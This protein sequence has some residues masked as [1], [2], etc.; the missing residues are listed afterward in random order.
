LALVSVL[1][2]IWGIGGGW[3]MSCGYATQ[4]IGDSG[5]DI[6]TGLSSCKHLYLEGNSTAV[7]ASMH[8]V[9]ETGM[10]SGLGIAGNAVTIVT[11]AGLRYFTWMAL[12]RK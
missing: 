4:A 6:D 12:G 9:N 5:G 8:V 7:S 10:I 2:K 1:Q 3:H 11:A